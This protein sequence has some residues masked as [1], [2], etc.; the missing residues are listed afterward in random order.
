MRNQFIK[1]LVIQILKNQ[2]NAIF[3][4]W[5]VLNIITHIVWNVIKKKNIT[6]YIIIIPLAIAKKQYLKD[7]KFVQSEELFVWRGRD[8]NCKECN[9]F[10]TSDGDCVLTCPIGT[11]K[12]IVNNSY[13]EN[14]PMDYMVYIDMC[15]QKKKWARNNIIGF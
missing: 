10:T 7:I 15:I 12:N 13:I 3:H 14:C 6:L 2:S 8:G 9:L 11:Y 5:L 1:R 4:V